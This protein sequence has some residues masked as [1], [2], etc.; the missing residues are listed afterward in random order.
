M[1]KS[2]HI[3]LALISF[4]GFITRVVLSEVNSEILQRKWLKISP[5]VIDTFLLASGITLVFQGNWLAGEYGWLTAK[6][7]A[8]MGY[9]GLGVVAMRC[10][11]TVRWMA[12]AASITCYVYILIVAISKNP[13]IFT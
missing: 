5:H 7:I 8:L 13:F 10:R 6:I 9:I 3:L 11:G 12:L 2:I 4:F 1:I